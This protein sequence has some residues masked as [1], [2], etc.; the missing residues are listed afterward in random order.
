MA[1]P[2]TSPLMKLEP[3]TGRH[4]R[5]NRGRTKGPARRSWP[6]DGF[7]ISIILCSHLK[8]IDHSLQESCR[9]HSQSFELMPEHPCS[10]PGQQPS[11]QQENA[12]R[13]MV[14]EKVR[15]AYS[16]PIALAKSPC[17]TTRGPKLMPN[18]QR[19]TVWLLRALPSIFGRMGARCFSTGNA[20]A[21]LLAGLG[22]CRVW[23]VFSTSS[24]P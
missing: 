23:A 14:I 20:V 5:A 17:G 15:R 10:G 1:D 9:S 11:S 13:L 7:S 3:C 2:G 18:A 12:V 8:R 24:R 22:V 19:P 6:D 16:I 21:C 4:K